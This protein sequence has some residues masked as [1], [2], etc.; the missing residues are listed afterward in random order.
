MG[1]RKI[2]Q[3]QD[4]TSNFK[5]MARK[6]LNCFALASSLFLAGCATT[7]NQTGPDTCM[8]RNGSQ[9]FGGFFASRN[10]HF[11]KECGEGQAI[12]A[13]AQIDDPRVK[14]AAAIA[15]KESL[16]PDTRKSFEMTAQKLGLDQNELQALATT[17]QR[18]R[19]GEPNC[20]GRDVQQKQPNG[21]S[22]VFV[23]LSCQ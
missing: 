2:K 7:L 15:A 22:V 17:A 23:E 4:F 19:D 6:G 1:L 18:R 10:D 14:A 5:S 3:N 9:A 21:K 8:E 20:I 13:M 16:S 12:G 11:N